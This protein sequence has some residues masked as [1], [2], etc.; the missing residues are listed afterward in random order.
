MKKMCSQIGGNLGQAVKK[1]QKDSRM[2]TVLL[3]ALLFGL[4]AHGF[5]FFS[6]YSMHD[7]LRSLFHGVGATYESGRWFLG[8]LSF[9][10]VY[11]LGWGQYSTPM[12]NG[13][14]SL[15]WLALA[16]CLIVQLL[17]IRWRVAVV[18][19]SGVMVTSPMLANLF[20]YMFTAPYYC[21][22]VFLAVIGVY[23]ICQ[24]HE[25]WTFAFGVLMIA[26]SAGIYQAYIPFALGITLL[27]FMK[28]VRG[29]N[30]ADWNVRKS[31]VRALYLC[32]AWGIALL[33]YFLFT[34]LFL[35]LKGGELTDYR[36]IDTMGRDGMSAYLQ[37][38]VYAYREFI[39][40]FFS[41]KTSNHVMYP[42]RSGYLY[43]LLMFTV[44]IGSIYEFF[45]NIRKGTAV[46]G[47]CLVIL[48]LMLPF[49][50]NF[51]YVM[52]DPETVYSL[53][54]YGQIIPLLY[55]IQMLGELH[56]CIL[57]KKETIRK[58][59][60][61]VYGA[62]AVLCLFPAFFSRYDNA[63]YMRAALYQQQATSWFTTLITRVESAPGYQDDLPVVYVNEMKIHDQNITR[64]GSEEIPFAAAGNSLE[65]VLNNY[66]WRYFVKAWCGWWP[67]EV[68]DEAEFKDR[69]EVT[70]MPSYPDDGA[71]QILDGT[72][73]IKF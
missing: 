73:V 32:L 13:L 15:F 24:W 70:R 14:L 53:M 54:L 42:M 38:T 27:Y 2:K 47:V 67:A 19:L 3:S 26:C 40:P 36:G 65:D 9:A 35:H 68:K 66:S 57:T 55:A 71:I 60:L 20:G 8:L 62:A 34:R 28:V 6:K 44:V 29:T 18:L 52:C 61:P 4:L 46:K 45:G 63:A 12:V 30:A 49:V 21:F 41:R 69:P 31:I 10:E 11:G 39:Q 56:A 5:C 33:L 7:D 48:T 64:D 17:D 23:A 58:W 50:S 25:F 51:I 43:L 59:K 16:A 37:R 1:L 72:V 22:A